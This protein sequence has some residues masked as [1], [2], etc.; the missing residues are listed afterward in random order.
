MEVSYA[1]VLVGRL[2]P[3]LRG[4][5]L[6]RLLEGRLA[7]SAAVEAARQAFARIVN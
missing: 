7:P 6:Q 5:F 3:S 4:L 1:V 2:V